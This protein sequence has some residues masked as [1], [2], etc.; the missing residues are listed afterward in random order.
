MAETVDARGTACPQ[1][2]VMTRQAL[3]TGGG[4]LRVLV[5]NA[6]AR[7]NV[8]RFARSQECEVTV[9]EEDFG[10]A[11][12]IVPGEGGIAA[13]AAGGGGGSSLFVLS[14]DF[15][16]KVDNELGHVLVKAF[17]NTLADREELPSHIILFNT[18]VAL[19]CGETETARALERLESLGVSVLAC[20]TCLDYLGLKDGLRAGVV[21]N[22][23]EIIDTLASAGKCITV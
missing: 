6:T 13:M 8:A 2:V 16:G 23:Y 3:V 1:P 4:P 17:L 10:F 11:L 5:D 9:A 18:G 14:S 20:G 15:M 22:M 7:D 12:D 19:A 21:S